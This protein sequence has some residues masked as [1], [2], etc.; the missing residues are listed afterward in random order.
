MVSF[1]RWGM[2]LLAPRCGEGA[3]RILEV[4]RRRAPVRAGVFCLA[5]LLV[6]FGISATVCP[7]LTNEVEVME[8]CR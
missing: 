6:E 4:R 8:V 3:R 1:L 2:S 7:D 5:E